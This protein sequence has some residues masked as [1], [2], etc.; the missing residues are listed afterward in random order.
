MCY[1]ADVAR[2]SIFQAAIVVAG[3][4]PVGCYTDSI[5]EAPTVSI[6]PPTETIVRGKAATFTAIGTDKNDGPATLVYDWGVFSGP[7]PADGSAPGGTSAQAPGSGATYAV[8][9][10][11]SGDYCVSVKVKD[12]SGASSF[13]THGFRVDDHAPT[14]V[15]KLVSPATLSSVPLYTKLRF[16]SQVDDVD[17]GDTVKREWTFARP[18]MAGGIAGAPAKAP[19]CP[20]APNDVC[21]DAALDGE[22]MLT[23]TVTDED[24]MKGMD[25]RTFTVAPDAAPC[26][27][28]TTPM[29]LRV[30]WA[31]ES[32]HTL[33]VESLLDDGDPF[34]GA[35]DG[36]VQARFLWS[37]R[38]ESSGLFRSVVMV[39]ELPQYTVKVDSDLQ[40]GD[41][42]QVRVEAADRVADRTD[43]RTCGPDEP[44]CRIGT[45]QRWVTW[46]VLVH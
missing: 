18:A 6:T 27:G 29:D 30:Q 8:T 2:L 21:F 42:F 23:L 28:V 36:P 34:P 46:T 37:V 43:T 13:Q 12:P 32:T 20:D 31:P 5:N 38:R 19:P 11:K 39:D 22:Y 40:I 9:P 7:C 15:I 35:T 1:R 33:R 41:T 26:I 17:Q 45:C 25:M 10:P 3:I 44:V 4:C 16:S 14:A 24:Q